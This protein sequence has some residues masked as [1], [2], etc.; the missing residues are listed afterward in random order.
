MPH[1]TLHTPHATPH[2]LVNDVAWSRNGPGAHRGGL[3]SLIDCHPDWAEVGEHSER[4]QPKLG[5]ICF[6]TQ[7]IVNFC[8]QPGDAWKEHGLCICWMMYCTTPI[9]SCS[10]VKASKSFA[11]FLSRYS[12]AVEGDT[13]S[14]NHNSAHSLFPPVITPSIGLASQT[15]LLSRLVHRQ[16]ERLCQSGRLTLYIKRSLSGAG[17]LTQ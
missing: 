5:E 11:H 12:K 17:S 9:P 10:G 3:L 8:V 13:E 7:D 14:W 2:T 4:S 15:F 1:R 6:M 16:F